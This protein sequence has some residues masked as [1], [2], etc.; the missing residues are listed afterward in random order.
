MATYTSNYN[1]SKPEQTDTQ[2]SFISAYSSNMDIIDK[3][4]GNKNIADEYDNTQTYAVGDFVIYEGDLYKCTTAVTTAE[5]F[6]SNKWTQTVASDEFGSGGGGSSTLAGLTDVD[7][8]NLSNG[9]I[10]KY[11]STTQKWENANESGGGGGGGHTII[12]ENDIEM[13]QRTG[14]HFTGNVEVTDDSVNDETVV[15]IPN[16]V[17]HL[18]QA[19]YDDLPNTKLS[20]DKIYMIEDEYS[21]SEED[22]IHNEGMFVDTSNVIGSG[23]YSQNF[24]Y[25][26]SQ[27]CYMYAVIATSNGTS[28]SI[29][30]DGKQIYGKFSGSGMQANSIL[31]PIKK[32]QTLVIN[33]TDSS[34]VDY[35]IYGIQSGSNITFLSEYASACYSTVEREVGCWVD[36]KPLYQKTIDF[37]ALPNTTSK[38][39]STPSNIENIIKYEGFCYSSSDITNQR[40]IPFSA[41]G[42]N[43][44]RAD[45][46]NGVLRILTFSNWSGYNGCLTVL[47]T[48]TTDT[49]GSGV[50]TPTGTPTVHYSTEEQV[51]GTWVDGSTLYQKTKVVPFSNF[52]HQND[53]YFTSVAE[54]NETVRGI[55]AIAYSNDY[56]HCTLGS[57][58]YT[59]NNS[60][61]YYWELAEYYTGVALHFV[62]ESASTIGVTDV[63]ITYQ[64]TKSS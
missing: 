29:T 39:L 42:S 34:S 57:M 61:S 33:A 50:W 36:G 1:L 47:Y 27:D 56:G 18:T 55:N 43:D 6:D 9:Q 37:G 25:T 51:I 64:Y 63:V 12:D 28:S 2:A 59:R 32:G 62:G 10:I 49:A 7:L 13:T 21:Q 52:T 45:L 40:P 38:N 22:L 24:T 35:K 4:M 23:T 30:I 3:Q 5:D 60:F 41:G 46:Y 48:K 54:G 17:I 53:I 15:D 19:E 31:C 8:N 14:L 44:I 26:A 11:N 16:E 20:D 58:N